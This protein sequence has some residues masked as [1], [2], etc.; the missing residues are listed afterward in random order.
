MII[1]PL[2]GAALNPA[3]AFGPALVGH[4]FDGGGKFLLVYV[5]GPIIGGLVA[6]LLYE[7]VLTAPGAT[8]EKPMEPVG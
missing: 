8:G 7:R 3:R 6:A 4:Q 2:T 1:G 5:L